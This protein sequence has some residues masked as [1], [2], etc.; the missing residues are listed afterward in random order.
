MTE[1]IIFAGF[2]GQGVLL[3]GR[4]VCLAAMKEGKE[5]THLPSYGAE[6]R[7]GTANCSVVVSDSEVAS[8]VIPRP[9]ICVVLNK[10]SLLRFESAVRPGGLLI[11]N[12]SLIDVDPQRDDIE[13]V[14]VPANDI[15]AEEGSLKSANMIAL[16]VLL[17]LKPELVSLDS[18]LSALEEAVSVRNKALNKINVK[19]LKRGYAL[20]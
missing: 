10:P 15:A 13:S 14:P 6:M 19:A 3:S 11:Y 17:K 12:S 5:V 7:G 9:T 4:L 1:E 18:I 16:G 20:V 8:P 2:G